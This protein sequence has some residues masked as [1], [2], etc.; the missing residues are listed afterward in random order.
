VTPQDKSPADALG[1]AEAEAELA[2]AE[3]AAA[4]AGV[5]LL[6]A[7]TTGGISIAAGL[8]T[9]RAEIASTTT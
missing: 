9:I 8:E 1:L 6:P 2:E 7:K 4:A 5:R 3:A